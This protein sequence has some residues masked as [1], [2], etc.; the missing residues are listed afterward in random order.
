[1]KSGKEV[2]EPVL[3]PFAGFSPGGTRTRHETAAEIEPNIQQTRV[4]SLFY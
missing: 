2:H 3:L 4:E 1:M